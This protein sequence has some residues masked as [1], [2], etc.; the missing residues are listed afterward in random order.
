MRR[1]AAVGIGGR[2]AGERRTAIEWLRSLPPIETRM[3]FAPAIRRRDVRL[4]HLSK[5]IPG[6][7]PIDREV[8]HGDG[9]ARLP[10]RR[11]DALRV[12]AAARRVARA[13]RQ[14][15][16]ERDDAE[17]AVGRGGRRGGRRGAGTGVAEGSTG[18]PRRPCRAAAKPAARTPAVARP[19]VAG[20]NQRTRRRVA[21][22]TGAYCAGR[23]TRA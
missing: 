9:Q 3:R 22:V 2:L 10:Q 11:R 6:L 5:K 15:V 17:G 14:R 23:R 8:L 19:S 4:L 18:S 21:S 13:A 12:A 1:A 16:A 7:R 20:R